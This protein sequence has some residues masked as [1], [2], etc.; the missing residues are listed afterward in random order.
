M[1]IESE[2]LAKMLKRHAVTLGIEPFPFRKLGCTDEFVSEYKRKKR[3]EFA[4]ILY[5][6]FD[7]YLGEEVK[8]VY[9]RKI[10]RKKNY[11]MYIMM[12]E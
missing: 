10:E 2:L 11:M 8:T 6:A 9:E 3:K 7:S 5:E 12:E 1:E 4:E